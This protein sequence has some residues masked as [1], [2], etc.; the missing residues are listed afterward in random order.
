MN[1]SV[2]EAQSHNLVTRNKDDTPG[3]RSQLDQPMYPRMHNPEARI[4]RK[5]ADPGLPTGGDNTCLKGKFGLP[6]IVQIR[7]KKEVF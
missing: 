3:A 5:K 4:L 6:V 2:G 1:Y 7:K